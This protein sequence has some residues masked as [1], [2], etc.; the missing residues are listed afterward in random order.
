MVDLRKFILHSDYS[1]DKIV[2]VKQGGPITVGS[3]ASGSATFNHG[4]PE[5]PLCTVTWSESSDFTNTRDGMETMDRYDIPFVVP[6]SDGTNVTVYVTNNTGSTKNVYWRVIMYPQPGTQNDF[7]KPDVPNRFYLDTRKN[8]FKI[9]KEGTTTGSAV[10]HNLG[11]RPFVSAW[12]KNSYNN[13]IYPIN[14]PITYS[15]NS[16]RVRVETDGVFF[17]MGDSSIIYYRIYA[18]G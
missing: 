5:A 10:Y 7:K 8:Y 14:S 18:D 2:A 12:Y 11:Y 13:R 16:E 4:L 17:N 9:V 15:A 1:L 3:Y 6:S